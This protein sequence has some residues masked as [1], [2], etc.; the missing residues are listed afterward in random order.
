MRL[1]RQRQKHLPWALLCIATVVI[2][3]RHV[4][5]STSLTSGRIAESEP[6]PNPNVKARVLKRE[7]GRIIALGLWARML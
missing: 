3:V 5:Q 4:A 6:E 7:T 2:W 1:V